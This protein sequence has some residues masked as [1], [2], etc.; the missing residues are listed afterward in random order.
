M[1]AFTLPIVALA[2]LGVN[3]TLQLTGPT[4]AAPAIPEMGVTAL[5]TKRFD[6]AKETVAIVLGSDRT[7]STDFLIPYEPF[8]ATGAYNVY[9]VAPERKMTS[10]RRAA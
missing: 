9:A 3:S 7:E 10:R 2:A 4:P 1:L 8:S 6:P 5:H